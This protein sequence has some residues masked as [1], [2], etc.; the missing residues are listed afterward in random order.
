[1]YAISSVITPLAG[2][3]HLGKIAILS[4]RPGVWRAI[5]RVAWDCAET[6]AAVTVGRFAL[7]YRHYRWHRPE[8]F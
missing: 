8:R 5:L 1:M 3:V 7:H 6:I 2:V 4:S